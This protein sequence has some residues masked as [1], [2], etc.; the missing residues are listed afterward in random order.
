MSGVIGGAGSKSGIIGLQNSP[1]FAVERSSGNQSITN[2]GAYTKVDFDVEVID[3]HGKFDSGT[4]TPGIVG[5]YFISFL[6]QVE[7]GSNGV[8]ELV[9]ANIRKN[10]ADITGVEARIDLRGNPGRGAGVSLQALINLD[11][12]DYI[13]GWVRNQ[14]T[15][16]AA[17]IKKVGTSMNGFRIF[18]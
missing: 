14:A 3:S 16:G 18:N 12:D 9:M 4:F 17:N 15:G 6:V 8:V 7:S 1:Y 2:N 13:D 5:T 11:A 10:G